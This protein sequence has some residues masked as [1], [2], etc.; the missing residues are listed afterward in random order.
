MTRPIRQ[1]VT[2]AAPAAALYRMYVNA[3]THAAITGGKVVV[4][5][6]RGSKFSAFGGLLRGRTLHTVPGR[7]IVQAWRSASF[8]KHDVD[9]TLVLRFVPLGA[10]RARI[11]LTHV[12]V[13]PHDHRGVTN[14]WKKYYWRPWRRYLKR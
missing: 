8:R 11:E 2:L 12:D 1:S 14:G 3:K 13:P 9:S 10:Q 7:L 5:A 6:R 4:S